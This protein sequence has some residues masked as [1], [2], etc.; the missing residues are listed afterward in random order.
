MNVDPHTPASAHVSGG[1]PGLGV[2][3][4][5][6]RA[7]KVWWSLMW[8]GLVFGGIAGG[9]A[10]FVIGFIMGAA[11]AS[12][13][14]IAMLTFWAGV[15]VAIPVGILVVRHVLRKSW[16]DFRIALVAKTRA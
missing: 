1:V 10:G 12:R 8:R 6:G 5:W 14:S 3:V 15:L 2:D 11:R 16:S 4:T 7:A 13:E 9:L